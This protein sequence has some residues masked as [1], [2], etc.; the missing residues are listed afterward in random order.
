LSKILF[1]KV[2]WK[3][4]ISTGNQWIEVQLN[5]PGATLIVGKNGAGKSQLLD[6]ISFALFGRPFR[7]INKPDLINTIT[8]KECVVELTFIINSNKFKVIRGLKPAIF[9]IYRNEELV[10]QAAESKDYQDAFEKFILKT[11]HK[12]FCQIVILGSAIF[13][14]F[15]ALDKAKKRGVIEDVM[16]LE[17]FTVMNTLLKPKMQKTEYDLYQAQ[18]DKRLIEEKLKLTYAH[19][20]EIQDTTERSIN[21]KKERIGAAQETINNHESAVN[22]LQMRIENLNKG[23]DNDVDYITARLEAISKLQIQL[24]QKMRLVNKDLEFF[25]D[26]DTCPTCTQEIDDEFK[27]KTIKEK[28]EHREEL[29]EGIQELDKEYDKYNRSN[30]AYKAIQRDVAEKKQEIQEHKIKIKSLE[31][32]ISTLKVDIE[33]ASTTIRLDISKPVELEQQLVDIEKSIGELNEER[34]IQGFAASMLKD[35]GIK[36]KIIK[37]YIPIINTLLSKYCAILDFFVDFQLDES[38]K[39]TIKSRFRDTFSYENFSQ[40]EKMRLDLA[41]MFTWR[42]IAKMRNSIDCSLIIFDEIL[43][44]SMDAEG[45]DNTMKLLES[46]APDT[47]IFI[48]SHRDAVSDKFNRVIQFEK[49]QNFSRVA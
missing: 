41:M 40:G 23:L 19:I 24:T 42:A 33:K 2:R 3:N 30:V 44:G 32:Y 20:K 21:E 11:N 34:T 48:I 45:I 31:G 10:S 46:V 29:R 43:D 25:V 49:H 14:P 38:F 27:K 1:E 7:N 37:S 18:N 36:A 35:D 26:N 17:I 39:E 4:F 16:D 28:G 47:S 6:A 5:T 15:M 22:E 9:E 13:T 12:S 8:D